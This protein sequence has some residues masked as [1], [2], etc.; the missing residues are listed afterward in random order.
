MHRSGGHS[1]AIVIAAIR[2]HRAPI[3]AKEEDKSM[4]SKDHLQISTIVALQETLAIC[5]TL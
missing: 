1:C 4:D 2:R 5:D 3:Q